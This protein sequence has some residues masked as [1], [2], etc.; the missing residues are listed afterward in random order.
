MSIGIKIVSYLDILLL[1]LFYL[2]VTDYGQLD[3]SYSI[4]VWSDF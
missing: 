2:F 4:N 3:L 1:F